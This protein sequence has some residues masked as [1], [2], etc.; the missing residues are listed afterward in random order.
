MSMPPIEV[1]EVNG[2]T[3]RVE[4]DE[5]PDDSSNPRDWDGKFLWV[6]FEHRNYTIGD[7]QID[8][9][10]FSIEC[11]ICGGSGKLEYPEAN[12]ILDCATCNGYGTESAETLA[13]LT[14]LVKHKYGARVIVPTGMM[15]HGSVHYYLGAS[16]PCPWDSATCGF[17]LVT[18]EMLDEWG[19][20]QTDEELIEGMRAEIAEY[21][22]WCNGQVYDVRVIDRNGDTVECIGGFI[23]DAGQELAMAEGVAIAECHTPPEPLYA[24]PRLTERQLRL[25]AEAIQGHVDYDHCPDEMAE[26]AEQLCTLILKPITVKEST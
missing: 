21:D 14:E 18:Q 7:E 9:R 24:I 3:V 23:G 12:A 16:N 13:E 1:R 26:F 25:I 2:F 5:Y 15:D 8:P 19:N 6:G 10:E 17:M 4:W 20:D 11:R 22:A